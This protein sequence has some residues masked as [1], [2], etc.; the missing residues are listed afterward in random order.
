MKFAQILI[1]AGVAATIACVSPAPRALADEAAP[2]RPAPDAAHSARAKLPPDKITQHSLAIGARKLAFKA[3]VATIRLTDQKDETLAEVVTTAYLLDGADAA[4]RPVTFVFNGGPGAASAFLQLGALG[5]WR[6]PFA[7]SPSSAPNLVD[8]ADTWLDFTDLVFVDPPGTGWSRI[9]A[10]GEEVRKRIWSVEGDIDALA[11]TVR[12]WL[13][14]NDRLASPKFIVGE[15][16]GGFRAPRLAQQLATKEGVGV[17]GMILISPALDLSPHF[18]PGETN[19]VNWAA[20]L[21]SYAAVAREAKG[22]ISRSDLADVESYAS[23][24]YVVDLL[25]G[26]K[27][28]GALARLTERVASF[29]GL[30]RDLVRRLDGRVSLNAFLRESARAQGKVVSYYDGTVQADDAEPAQY[31]SDSL[32]PVADGLL[33]SLTSAAVDLYERRL[34]WKTELRYETLSHDVNR[35]WDWG[36]APGSNE[37]ASALRRVLALDPHLRVLV[38]HGLTDLQTPYFADKLLLDQI[39]DFKPPGRLDLVVYPGGHMLYN[40]DES[41][42]ALRRDAQRLIDGE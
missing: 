17:S 11:V 28:A 42:K 21:P 2:A 20:R 4:K 18:S 10:N 23:G 39:P 9:V 41:R 12:R 32:D 25:R 40:R 1:A 26:T 7:F 14:L 37:S 24:E 36:R 6:L 13:A 38:A 19:P 8:N 22:A 29:T 15:S 34:G 16:Y 35:A 3:N 5:P 30:D 31:T 27:D 33:A